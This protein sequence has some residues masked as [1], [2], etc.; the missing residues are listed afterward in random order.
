MPFNMLMCIV[1]LPE[2]DSEYRL[3]QICLT[4]KSNFLRGIFVTNS[5]PQDTHLG[6]LLFHP[7][8]P[9]SNHPKGSA[10]GASSSH[11]DTPFGSVGAVVQGQAR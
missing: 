6:T 2:E 9:V 4:T 5:A 1:T 3:P 10:V 8:C 11:L 7:V